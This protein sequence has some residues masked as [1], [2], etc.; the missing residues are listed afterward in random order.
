[1]GM[2]K[3]FFNRDRANAEAFYPTTDVPKST[4]QEAVEAADGGGGGGGGAP[5]DAQYLVSSIDGTLTNERVVGNG[6][7]ITWDFTGTG[8]AVANL[9]FLGFENLTDPNADR[10]PF[11]DDSAGAFAWMSPGTGIGFSETSINVTGELLDIMNLSFAAGDVLY[12]DGTNMQRLAAGTDGQF[13]RTR[14][15]GGTPPDWVNVPGGGDLLRANNLSDLDDAATARTNLG[16]AIG[17]DVQAYDAGLQSIS[18]LTTAAD[19]M[20]YTTALDTYAVTDLTTFGRS[21]I[22]DAT[23]SDARTTLGLVIGTHVQAWDADLDAWAAVNPSSYSTTAQIAAAYQPLDSDLTSIAALSTTAYGRSVLELAN[24]AAAQTLFSVD[25]AG[26]DNSTN[27]T[28]VTTSHDYLSLAGQAITLG[29]IDLTADVT[30]A[31]PAASVSI[32]DSGNIITAT[33]VEGALAE[34]RAAID[35]IELDYL[36][37]SDIANMLETSDIGVTVQAYDAD[38]AK[39]DD[40]TANFTGTLQNG[41]SN[42]LVDSDIGSTVQ[43]YD[44]DLTTWAGLTPSANAQSLVTAANYAAMRALLDLESGTDFLS[45]AAIAAAYQ[46]LDGDLT[47]IAA[48]TTTAA[49]RSVLTIADPNADRVIAW[50]DTAGAMAAIAL[51]DITSE[52]SPATGDFILIYGAEGDLR[53]VDWAD[54]PGAGAGASTALDNLASVAI[55][56]TLVSDTNNTDDLGTGAI[57]WRTAYLGTSLELGHASD[58]TITRA[59][60][61]VIAVEGSNVLMASNIGSTVQAYDA[62]TL[63]ADTADVLTAGFASTPYSAGT[64]S[65]GTYTPDE[66]NG[67]YQY[68]T[69][70]GAHTLAPPTNSGSILILYA[71]NGSAGTITTSGFTMVTGDSLTTTNGHEFFFY[72]NKNNNGTGFS[73]LHVT[74]LQ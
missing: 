16:V 42:V 10:L 51:A 24:A 11:W 47:S 57:A 20:I 68:A 1:M 22:D 52:A 60:A 36:Q 66:A 55:N 28:L 13:L 34:N 37:A 73:H 45:P 23:A 5:T 39:Y 46:P 72:V 53:K 26:T 17:N 27:V 12:H 50:D 49:G 32:A 64:F 35:A 4:T 71:N 19:K 74:A 44:A 3:G 56:T 8:T 21:L 67:N 33:T 63:K 58:T 41:G 54:L 65:T 18:G 31:L 70:G 62:D 7:G 59:S 6:T 61:G 30:G 38:T 14:G 69:N 2:V 29:P 43:A 9:D 25:P 48:L 15:A 40:V